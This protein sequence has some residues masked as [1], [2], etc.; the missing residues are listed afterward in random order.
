MKL[1]RRVVF[2]L[3]CHI[4]LTGDVQL[5][6]EQ[7]GQIP[8]R[9]WPHF[10]AALSYIPTWGDAAPSTEQFSCP[11]TCGFLSCQVSIVF[12]AESG[13]GISDGPEEALL[14]IYLACKQSQYTGTACPTTDVL[15]LTVL[16]EKKVLHI[17]L[18]QTPC[19]TS[20][21]SRSAYKKQCQCIIQ[22]NQILHARKVVLEQHKFLK[23]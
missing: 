12:P 20:A 10:S 5:L 19:A 15:A 17:S 11:M 6:L 13:S 9:F 18:Q 2:H 3:V 23:K 16:L 8:N 21:K 4:L 1:P 22:N 7:P 14:P